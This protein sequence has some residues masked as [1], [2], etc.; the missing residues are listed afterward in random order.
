MCGRKDL[1]RMCSEAFAFFSQFTMMWSHM[2]HGGQLA[3]G[4]FGV[5]DLEEEIERIAASCIDSNAYDKQAKGLNW[6]FCV[7]FL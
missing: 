4:R 3:S 2:S 5:P 1:F 6:W 7:L